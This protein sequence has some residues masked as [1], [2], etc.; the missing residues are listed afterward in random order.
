[1]RYLVA[2]IIMV[3]FLGFNNVSQAVAPDMDLNSYWIH[4]KEATQLALKIDKLKDKY[5]LEYKDFNDLAETCKII[6]KYDPYVRYD[7]YDIASII[8]KESRFN[9]RALNKNDGGKGLMQPTNIREYHRDTLYW[10][11]VKKLYNKEYNII[12]GLI[13]LEDNLNK[14]KIKHIATKRY[15][16]STFKSELYARDVA[17]IKREIKAVKI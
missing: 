10:L 8:L 1:M 6:V 16:G 13:I 7:K 5:Y 17:K 14:Y 4:G 9:A 15:N 2:I 12:A 11:P 3:L